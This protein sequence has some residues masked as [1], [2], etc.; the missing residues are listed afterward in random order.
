MF[1]RKSKNQRGQS[2]YHVVESYREGKKIRQRVLLSLGK[3]EDGNLEKLIDS[4]SRFTDICTVAKMAD[5]VSVEKSFILGP[6]L[7]LEKLFEQLGINSLLKYIAQSHDKVRFDLKKIVFTIV[8]SRF[9]HPSSK[10]KVFE[11]WQKSFYPEMLTGDLP[12]HHIY[13]AM[14]LIAE[15]KDDIEQRLFW[16]GRD[17]L[18]ESVDVVLYDLTTLRFESV[19]T[20][21]GE[22]RQ[23]GYSKE[24]R[25]DC[26]QVVFGLLVDLHGIPLGFE[27]YPGNTFEGNTIPDIVEKMKKKF[28]VRRFVFV[29]DRGI[30][31]KKNLKLLSGNEF[32]VGMKISRKKEIEDEFYNLDNYTWMEKNNLAFYETKYEGSRSIVTWSRK[33]QE[34]DRAIRREVLE[35]IKKKLSSKKANAANFVSNKSYKKYVRIPQGKDASPTLN[36]E[37]VKN[38]ERKDGFFAVATNV[39]DMNAAEII[40]NYKALWKIE[41]AFGEF[42]G[43]LKARPVFHWTDNRIIGHLTLC[44][45]AYLCEAHLTKRL[46]EKG[47]VLKSSAIDNKTI[48]KRPLTVVEAMRE[49]REVRAVPVDIRNQTVWVRTDISG[50]ATTLLRASGVRIP[51]KMLKH[52]PKCS[53]T[54]S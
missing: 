44:F 49:L 23:F 12:L 53:G 3:V 40:T 30:F 22:L 1:I 4:A 14:D 25:T 46:R 2:Y 42:K 13:R 37:A 43:N 21:L 15:H 27:V 6:L 9:V 41:D 33:R 29:A 26:T 45:I 51:P 20:D 28:D 10:L 16:H 24:M 5:S 11:H 48:K 38:A 47:V 52:S 35:K 36:E 18:S 31:S 39:K 50:N 8:A 34:R 32:I 54:N 17:I 19:R 7:V